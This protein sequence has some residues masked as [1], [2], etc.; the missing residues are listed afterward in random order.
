MRVLIPKAKSEQARW[1]QEIS[2]GSH[3]AVFVDPWHIEI[4]EQNGATR[5]IWMNLDAYKGVVCI[6]PTAAKSLVDALDTYWPMPPAEVSWFCNGPRT[7]RT[8]LE[9]DIQPIY[10]VTGFTAED[11]IALPEAK[12]SVGDKWLIVKG[13]AGRL[14]YQEVLSAKGCFVDVVEVYRREMSKR[15]LAQMVVEASSSDALW[16]SSQYLGDQLLQHNAEFWHNWTGQWWVSSKR[17]QNW[18]QSEKLNNIILADG[19]TPEAFSELAR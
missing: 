17:I 11:V 14:T 16:L 18:A 15:G 8:I 9:A 7:A 19:A 2:I 6:S 12:T 13:E 10:P 1:Q 5:Q 4:L 3:Q